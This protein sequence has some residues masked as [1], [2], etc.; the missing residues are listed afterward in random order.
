MGVQFI[1]KTVLPDSTV[2]ERP[3]RRA[4]GETDIP[5]ASAATLA[6]IGW[7]RRSAGIARAPM[8]TSADQAA[9]R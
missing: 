2:L 4:N 5:V 9:I 1:L 8:K 7:E 6:E 3:L